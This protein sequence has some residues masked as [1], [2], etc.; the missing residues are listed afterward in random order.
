MACPPVRD[1]EHEG[2]TRLVRHVGMHGI[3]N[4]MIANTAQFPVGFWY[5][6]SQALPVPGVLREW[7]FLVEA[8]LWIVVAKVGRCEGSKFKTEIWIGRENMK[9][10]VSSVLRLAEEIA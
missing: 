8:G 10:A 6:C 7:Y 2:R 1:F 4:K 3:E 5:S 9:V